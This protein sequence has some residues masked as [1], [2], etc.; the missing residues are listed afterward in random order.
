MLQYQ[1]KQDIISFSGKLKKMVLKSVDGESGVLHKK[2][3]EA[4]RHSF[5]EM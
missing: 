3:S 5:T 1:I 2:Q 4:H